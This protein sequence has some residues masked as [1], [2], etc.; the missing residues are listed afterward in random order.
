MVPCGVQRIDAKQ[1]ALAFAES[2]FF[3]EYQPIVELGSTKVPYVEALVRWDHP[4]LGVLSPGSFL[5]L[6]HG[7]NLS[8]SLTEWSIRQVLDDLPELRDL[9]GA[10]VAV[11]I[12]LSQRQLVDPEA[13]V[14]AIASSIDAA[15]EDPCSVCIEVVEDLTS[16]DIRRSANA[17]ADLRSIGLRVFLDDFG[18]G[19]SSLTALTEMDYDGLKIDRSFVRG[20]ISGTAARSVIEAILAFGAKT[21][22]SVVAE[23][24][25]S[26]LELYE[27][28]DIGCVLGQGYFLG[29]P[30]P[31]GA[32]TE[33]AGYVA[34]VRPAVA[35]QAEPIELDVIVAKVAAIN[36]RSINEV[37]EDRTRKLKLLDES[38]EALGE[39]GD[40]VRCEIGRKLTLSA[41]YAGEV[42]A[43]VRWGME[44]S[45]H[46]ERVEQWGYSAEALSIIAAARTS[47][48]DMPGI[49]IEAM[50][51]ALEIRMTKPIDADRSSSIDNGIGAVF[52][53]LGLW[54]NAYWWWRDSLDRQISTESVGT[55]MCCLNLIEL[56]LGRLEGFMMMSDAMPR[57]V[58]FALVTQILERLDRNP[59]VPV[60]VTPGFRCRL[61]LLQGDVDAA[62]VA[63]TA[64]EEPPTDILPLFLQLRAR[65][66]LAQQCE[67]YDDFLKYT[68]ELTAVLD[69]HP[70]LTHHEQ[71]AQQLHVRALSAVGRHDEAVRLLERVLGAQRV[72]DGEKLR[73]L[74][75]WIRMNVDLNLR[76][77]ELD[78]LDR[79]G[80]RVL[81]DASG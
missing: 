16:L 47:R 2:T 54:D 34:D 30:T 5:S 71:Q 31:L 60:G 1:I 77:A 35:R 75:G 33:R 62:T 21:G 7:D 9:H 81:R 48:E 40:D 51:R 27:L 70:L 65:A 56:E 14:R 64:A 15:D 67:E 43:A 10:D 61:E 12:N 69:G 18:T 28:E 80:L 19:A 66:M 46:A 50:T 29:R 44:T 41:V 24:V 52:A 4:T 45:R 20:L 3:F 78:V 79:E 76:L 36:P 55:A 38:A 22:I 11:T 8:D 26:A 6:I 74:F 59:N 63:I 57:E 39:A 49:R 25:E 42:D 23:G 37:F 73:T 32:A 17:I 53:N 13:T 68:T 72:Q 58:S